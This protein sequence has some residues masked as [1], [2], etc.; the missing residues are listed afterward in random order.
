M[1]DEGPKTAA[2]QLKRAV[3][4]MVVF[5]T[6][7]NVN[8]N[9]LMNFKRPPF[10]DTRVRRAISLAIDRRAYVQAVRP[11]GAPGGASMLP[12]PSG[13]GGLAPDDLAG[14]PGSRDPAKHKAQARHP[15]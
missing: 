2:E 3:P 11:G 6:S 10:T 7:T 12:R 1:P 5:E 4:S 15:P 9:L 8:D 13:G 14:L